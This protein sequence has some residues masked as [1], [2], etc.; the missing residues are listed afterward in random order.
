MEKRLVEVFTSGCFLCEEAVSIVRELACPSCEVKVYDLSQ[1]EGMDEAREK[2]R[3]YGVTSVP[4]VV[5]N[6]K[7]AECC[8]RRGVD[9]ATLAA[10][11]VGQPL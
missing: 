1:D 8:Q 2:A 3:Q 7:L 6:G 5:V 4:A 10:A 11:G 9:A